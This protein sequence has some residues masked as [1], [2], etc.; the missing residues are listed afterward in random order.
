[1]PN[2]LRK[3]PTRTTMIRLR[4]EA[5]T[6]RR[7]YSIIKLNRKLLISDDAFGLVTRKPLVFNVQDYKFLTDANKVKAY[8]K[9]LQQQI[10]ANILS[11]D[12]VSGKPRNAT[13][14]ESAY[15]KGLT[16]AYIDVHKEDL[17]ADKMFYAG[18]KAQF[19]TDA[20]AAPEVLSKIELIYTRAFN[21]MKGI[22]DTMSTQLSRALANGLVNGDGPVAISRE[23]RKT[24]IG[25]TKQRALLIARTEV[26]S[27]HAEGQLDAFERMGVEELGLMAEVGTAGDERVCDECQGVADG[28]PYTVKEARGMI[29]LHP[30]CR[31]SWEPYLRE[32]RRKRRKLKLK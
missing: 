21:D 8:Q 9:W 30:R 17:A 29:P 26:I 27:A 25:I 10:D 6:R 12:T 19:L 23:M 3:D 15:R 22:T 32:V 11:V 31:C 28:G 24:V 20:F 2:P 16:R 14:V 5:E 4:W 7:F 1:M 18:G 13:Y